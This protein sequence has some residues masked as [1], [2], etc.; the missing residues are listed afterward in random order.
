MARFGQPVRKTTI[1][2]RKLK[3]TS[4]VVFRKQTPKNDAKVVNPVIQK[5]PEKQK[6][7][8]THLFNG[9]YS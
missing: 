6:N 4:F 2:L 7:Q 3:S 9:S 8:L 5:Y 1:L